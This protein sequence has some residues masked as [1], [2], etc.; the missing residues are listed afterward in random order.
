MFSKFKK[1]ILTNGKWLW[2]NYP[3]IAIPAVA[4][5]VSFSVPLYFFVYRQWYQRGTVSYY[6]SRYTVWRPDDPHLKYMRTPSE[7]PPA[8][9]TIRD[10]YDLYNPDKDY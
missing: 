5:V 4:A 9:V 6:K 1:A 10:N 8:Y 3:E 7:Y 2:T